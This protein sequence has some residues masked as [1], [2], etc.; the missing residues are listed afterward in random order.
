[1]HTNI[2]FSNN[3]YAHDNM[4]IRDKSLVDKGLWDGEKKKKLCLLACPILNMIGYVAIYWVVLPVSCCTF[5]RATLGQIWSN[6]DQKDLGYFPMILFHSLETDIDLLSGW[7]Y[8]Y[9]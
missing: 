3:S 2:Q 7:R 8:E 1:M 4:L 5:S 9:T 6:K